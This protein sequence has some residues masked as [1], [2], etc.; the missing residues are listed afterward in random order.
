[1]EMIESNTSI[2]RRRLLHQSFVYSAMAALGSLP[3]IA[4]A[5][6]KDDAA[7][8]V[9]LIGDWGYGGD[10][11]GQ[12]AVAHG[13]SAYVRE[14][15]I[16]P[17]TLL[18]LGDN[19]YG[20]LEGGTQ[21]P[22]WKTQFEDMYPKDI[23]DCPVYAIAGNHDY[24]R[25]PDSKVDAELAYARAGKTRWTMPAKWYSFE[26]PA[27]HPVMT[28]I[29]LDSNMPYADGSSS[30]GRD[31]TLTPQEQ[32][33]QLAWL[34]TELARPRKTPFTVVMGHHPVYSNGPHGDHQVLIRDWEPL[35]R[36]HKVQLYLAGHDHDLQHLE[37]EGHPTSFVLSGGGGADLYDL[38]VDPANRGPFAQKVYGFSHLS[39][40]HQKLTLR[41]LDS[42]GKILHA[43]S[44]TPDGATT[45]L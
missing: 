35:L 38:K 40:T 15:G 17:Q 32:A 27:K 9:I 45:I 44:K 18:M 16:K 41:H 34:K 43:F 42:D 30:K 13:M 31:F 24:Q 26:F 39:L 36:E 14:H 25:W 1:M 4:P 12:L 21:S 23:F 10:H 20:E 5:M 11:A 22:R 2:T 19:W 29:A 33:E 6:V 7:T 8:D 28:V 37:F 3:R